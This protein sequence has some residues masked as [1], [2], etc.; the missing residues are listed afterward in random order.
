MRS[1]IKHKRLHDSLILKTSLTG[2]LY[3]ITFW[4]LW[5]YRKRTLYSLNNMHNYMK[6]LFTFPFL[7]I[8]SIFILGSKVVR[9]LIFQNRQKT[10]QW[11]AIEGST[12]TWS[13]MLKLTHC[14]VC[15]FFFSQNI[16][17]RPSSLW[18]VYHYSLL[19]ILSCSQENSIASSFLCFYFVIKTLYI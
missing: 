18:Y 14:N 12:V 8:D 7:D 11:I 15:P 10:N 17:K 6:I 2:C 19:W 16:L 3:W 1:K 13:R 4:D 9:F 5:F